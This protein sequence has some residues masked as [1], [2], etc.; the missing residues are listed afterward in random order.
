MRIESVPGG[1]LRTPDSPRRE[2]PL[3]RLRWAGCPPQ[4]AALAGRRGRILAKLHHDLLDHVAWMR[5]DRKHDRVLVRLRLF[6]C[7]KLAVEQGRRHEMTVACR[8]PARD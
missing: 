8:Q 1:P 2:I 7:R 6:E 4:R 3:G 5:K